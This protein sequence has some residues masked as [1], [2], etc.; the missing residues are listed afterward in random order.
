MLK[1]SHSEFELDLS[2]F[3][4]SI[5][6]ENVWFK[7]RFFTNYV[8]PFDFK[9]TDEL[10]AAI[11]DLLSY[12]AEETETYFEVYFYHNGEEHQAIFEI[13]EYIGRDAQGSVRFGLEELPN[14]NKKLSE[15]PL[16]DYDILEPN[17]IYSHAG[18]VINKT[19]PEVTHNFVQVHTDKFS[20]D[21]AQWEAFE[22]VI[23]KRVG[24]TFVL[25][26]YDA[27]TDK[28][29]N[30]NIMIPQPYQLYVLQ[31]AVEDAGFVLAGDILENPDFK[32]ALFSEISNY[33]YTINTDS[34]ELFVHSGEHYETYNDNQY[35]K[36]VKTITLTEK[37]RYKISGNLTMRK[38]FDNVG[39]QLKYNGNVIWKKKRVSSYD[40][41]FGYAGYEVFSSQIDINVDFTEGAEAI[42][43]YYS[44]QFT[45]GFQDEQWLNDL[46][47]CD[48]TITQ[49]SKLDVNGN[50][51]PTLI[52]PNKIKLSK[53]VPDITVDDFIK[54]IKNWF[55]IDINPEGNIM[56][57]NY[58]E[59]QLNTS[60]VKSLQNFEV[61]KPQRFSNK[62]KS[63]LLKFQD[64]SSEDYTF[65]ETYVDNNG[66]TSSG[67]VT[68]EDTSEII[69]N[70]I[71][72][73]IINRN[74]IITVHHFLDD[75]SKIKTILYDGTIAA[76]NVAQDNSNLLIPAIHENYYRKWLIFRI[77][78]I[79]FKWSFKMYEEQMRDLNIREKV[80]AYSNN[81]I[82]KS[83]SKDLLLPGVWLIEIETESIKH[84]VE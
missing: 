70:A 16:D 23:N 82:I 1:I 10:N 37:G 62:G 49:L 44:Y 13:E 41:S 15:L 59:N 35:G 27:E 36:F 8:L 46:P 60:P 55:N 5:V 57:F 83:L 31:K 67:I 81:H 9:I 29:L 51:E 20:A 43:E 76:L 79:P 32:V 17:T 14:Y 47:I 34:K 30:R 19:W 21:D 77:H 39:E 11:G 40:G 4:I 84:A 80:F 12:N 7:D 50:F 22:G 58:I 66:A 68:R 18:N 48:L 33:Y 65:L 71:P 64:V 54:S 53:C 2:N 61:K 3:D 24:S 38:Y 6:E 26:E 25:N 42:I 28:Q 52:T 45:R 69:I 56:Y 74:G 75:S 72:L 63:F 78:G 73:P